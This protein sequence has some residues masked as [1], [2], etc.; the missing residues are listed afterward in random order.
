VTTLAEQVDASIVPERL[1]AILAGFFG[2]V[3]ALLVAIG[4]FGLLACTVA[5]QTKEIGVRVAL[6]A[7]RGDVIR[8]VM[9]SAGW[10]VSG[11]LLLGAPAAFWSTRLAASIVENLPARGAVPIAAAAAALIAVALVA[12]YVP[13]RRATRV[14]PV[15]ALRSE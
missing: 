14:E 3:G 12:A 2:A 10:V 4:V 13:A 7:T 6:G 9:A 1:M 15:I 5:R 11:G 8:M